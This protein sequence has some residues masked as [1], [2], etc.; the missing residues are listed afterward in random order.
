MIISRDK[1]LRD[2]MTH[3]PIDLAAF[4]ELS[5]ILAGMVY[6]EHQQN[7][8]IGYLSPDHISIQRQ[9][10]TARISGN[11][12]GHAAY[13]SP[14]QFGRFNLVPS[15][16]SDLYALGVICYELLTGQLPFYPDYE[17]DWSTVHIRKVP[18][19]IS[20]IRPEVDETLQ[21]VLMKLLAKSPVDRYQSAYGLLEDLLLYQR[22]LASGGTLAPFQVGRLDTI[23][24]LSL[25][26]CWY[27]RS[28]AVMQMEA[29]LEQAFQ[30]LNAFRWVIGEAGIGK[31]TLVNKLEQRVVQR[32]GKMIVVQAEPSGRSVRCGLL[33]RVLQQWT[34]Q[35]WSEPSDVITQLKNNLQAKFNREAWAVIVSCWPEAKLLLDS[36][37][38]EAASVLGDV[39]VWDQFEELL[40][41]L[42][43]CMAECKPPLVVFVDNLHWADDGTQTVIRALASAG[44]T[45]GLLLI[46]A[47]QM[48]EDDD[49]TRDGMN[50]NQVADVT[51]LTERCR[52]NPEE[53]VALLPLDNDDVKQ[54]VSDALHENSARIRLLARSVRDQTG[55]NPRSI[56]LLLEG[57][58][59]E[60]RLS[61]DE[62]RR[63]WVWDSEVV[64][65]ISRSEANLHLLGTTLSKLQGDRKEFLAMAAAIGPIFRLS[66][67]AEACGRTQ[68]AAFRWLEEAEAEGIIYREYDTGQD[69]EHDPI[70]LFVHESIHQMAYALDSAGNMRRHRTIG[71][72]LQRYAS[73]SGSDMPHAAID[74]LNLAVPV[75]SETEMKQLM[76]HNLQA[77]QEA[78]ACGRYARGKYY[79]ESG[80]QLSTAGTGGE[81]GALDLNTELQLVLVWAEYMDGHVERAKDR[82]VEL[83]KDSG[84][85]SRAERINIWAPLIQFHAFADNAGAIQYGQEALA[86]YGWKLREKSS[87]LSI[88]KEVMQ[89]GVL[90]YRKRDKPLPVA[91][92]LDKEYAELCRLLELLFF[93]LLVH[94]GRA[95]LELYARF[96]RYGLDKG[97][98]ESLAIIIGGYELILQRIFPSL[99]QSVPIAE[100]MFLQIGDT[101]TLRNRHL[102]TFLSGM[103]KQIDKPLEAFATIFNAMRQGLESGDK[104]FANLVLMICMLGNNGNLNAL[105]ELLEYFED[106]MR[107][108]ADDKTL[109][110]VMLTAGYVAALQD[111]SRT[112]SFVAIPQTRSG[113]DPEQQDEDNYSC[114]CRL[115]A[116]YISG[117]YREALY[118]AKRGR[119]N[120][121][122]LDWIRIRK[123][124]VFE[125][126]ALSALFFETNEEERKRIRKAIRTQLRKMKSWRGFMGHASSAY[127]LV[128]AEEERTNGDLMEAVRGYIAAI[129]RA[130]SEKYVL[131]EAIACERLATYYQDDALSRSGAAITMMDACAA[132]ADWGITSKVTQIRSRYAEMLHPISQRYE[133]PVLEGQIEDKHARIEMSRRQKGPVDDV[134]SQNEAEYELVRRLVNGIGGTKDAADWTT[135]LLEAALRQAGADRG[136]VL[137]CLDDGFSIEADRSDRVEKGATSGLY[138]ESVLRHTVMTGEPLVLHDASRSFWVKDTY[139]AT[140]ELRS[141]LCMPIAVPGDRASY[142]LYLE[143]RQMP[144]VFLERDIQVLD[145]L[146]TR[147]IYLHMLEA[148]AAAAS[149]QDAATDIVSSALGSAQQEL[150][151]PLTEREVEIVTAMAEGMSNREIADRFGIAETTVKT[152]TSRIIGK[153]GVKRRGQAVV[154]AKELQLI[155]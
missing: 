103:S 68:D 20:D 46:G 83:N 99:V 42:I 119:A 128:K 28:A 23:R 78:L 155:K 58:L 79:A 45:S 30:G 115:E 94:D 132:Y 47:C 16:R 81:T 19:P 93:P 38:T 5:V 82:L 88:A 44:K 69:N 53:Q 57:W 15:G 18:Q 64:R 55:G 137:K 123:Q 63:Q 147:I 76:E 43:R 102:L 62:T 67:L 37:D 118:W 117:K 90:L 36:D 7:R 25:S 107:Q 32:G 27:G 41:D 29:G 24:T 8:V 17:E 120:E 112:D 143:N 22:M 148:E 152:H 77:G 49:S 84:R 149:M 72:L 73:E 131:M 122:P 98:N 142:L 10:K 48:E 104:D 60:K 31:T 4:I 80:L 145:L 35:L 6:R 144:G 89:T 125:T 50:S 74:H 111:E 139:I 146:A 134:A 92:P 91:D 71:Q 133:G 136:L 126:L 105:Q 100:R 124:R 85:L 97:A 70:Y 130:R 65:L 21:A 153:L 106:N 138:A 114:G 95:L 14:E 3:P 129:G 150:T 26:H 39:K 141:I 34:H 61:F 66:N 2:Y 113:G 87:L 127:L 11:A 154:R 86:A 13:R 56:R 108:N 33:L 110:M 75:L 9:E 59:Q 151:E 101:T 12:E 51:W 96:I 109:E 121:L 40:P 135:K 1:I 54:L 52:A 140:G 116:A